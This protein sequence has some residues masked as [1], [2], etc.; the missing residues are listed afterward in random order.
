MAPKKS[1]FHR[2]FHGNKSHYSCGRTF[3]IFQTD[4]Y[5][6]IRVSHP[7]DFE[8]IHGLGLSHRLLQLRRRGW[9]SCHG[10][11]GKSVGKRNFSST[12][13]S[14]WK[15]VKMGLCTASCCYSFFFCIITHI[16]WRKTPT[17]YILF[18]GGEFL[19]PASINHIV[20]NFRSCWWWSGH[21]S[22]NLFP[23]N[24][25]RKKEC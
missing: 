23:L 8:W 16:S 1:K 5:C 2:R 18:F 11:V 20:A 22:I 15:V 13:S 6:R 17:W 25:R 19:F 12:G 4:Y 24:A 7:F 14:R 21:C 9:S 3:V 10:V